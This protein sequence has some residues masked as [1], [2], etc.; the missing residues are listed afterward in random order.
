MS[1]EPYSGLLGAFPYAFRSSESRLF[2]LYAVVGG[3]LALAVA[4]LFGL[5]LV[6]V[7]G[8]TATAEGGTFTFSRSL[9]VLVGLFAVAPLVA[10]VLFV[11]RHH[12]RNGAD[13]GF[14]ARMATAGF[15]FVLALYLAA[16]VS[17]PAEQ[18][19]T[20]AGALAPVADTLYALPRPLGPAI[21]AA[22]AVGMYLLARRG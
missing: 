6:A 19:Q 4:L 22:V 7:L 18:Q 2:R 20:T 5:A 12:R 11:A 17:T 10:P 8:Q 3:L 1:D 16:V 14:D 13:R 21:P 15:L 9:Y